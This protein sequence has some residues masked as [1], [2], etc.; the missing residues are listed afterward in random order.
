MRRSSPWS[1]RSHLL[2]L[3]L[4]AVLPALLIVLAAG[5]FRHRALLQAS[6]RAATTTALP[7]AVGSLATGSSVSRN[8]LFPTSAATPGQ[9]SILTISGTYQGGSFGFSR[10]IAAP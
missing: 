10:R 7:V 4:L 3:V 5:L 6:E 8:L 2:F 1:L 9:A